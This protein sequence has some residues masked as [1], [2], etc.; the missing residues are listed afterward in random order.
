MFHRRL[1]RTPH[2][3]LALAGALVGLLGAPATAQAAQRVPA[4]QAAPAVRPLAAASVSCRAATGFLA[5][6]SG[7]LYEVSDPNVLGG[8]GN[9]T[10][11]A[12]VGSSWTTSDFA[13]MGAGGDGV[14]Y[15]LTWG[16]QLRWYRWDAGD[17]SWDPASGR[18]VGT[19]FTPIKGIVNIGLGVEGRFYVVRPN[20]RLVEFEHTGWHTG[21]ATWEDRQ[22]EQIGLG[23]KSTDVIV[24]VGDGSLYLQRAGSLHWYRHTL[25]GDGPTIWRT[26]L[27]GSGWSMY[28]IGSAGG[29]V[30]YTT[31]GPDGQVKLYQHLDPADGAA[32]WTAPQGVAKGLSD[33]PDSLGVVIDPTTC[34][35]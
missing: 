19:G 5:L 6:P 16:G 28:A 34:S 1:A 12:R 17:R 22:G 13:W 7:D 27:V 8:T 26:R 35:A 20:G 2:L 11:G 24:P 3:S 23:W 30:L 10:R 33:E 29:G 25:P 14:L 32:Q 21:S 4:V 31:G 9:L 15:G 18:V